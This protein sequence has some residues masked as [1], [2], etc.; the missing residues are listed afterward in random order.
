MSSLNYLNKAQSR[1]DSTAERQRKNQA[2]NR[3]LNNHFERRV[4]EEELRVPRDDERG[5][6][7]SDYSF[8]P[9]STCLFVEFDADTSSSGTSVCL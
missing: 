1:Y 6:C 8:S 2:I 3:T 5:N 4:V 7:L 9:S